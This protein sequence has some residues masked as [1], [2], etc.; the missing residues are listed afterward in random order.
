LA[1]NSPGGQLPLHSGR[2]W[3]HGVGTVELVVVVMLV[4]VVV[5]LVD[6]VAQATV[7]ASQQCG[8]E[9]G[10]PPRAAH[11]AALVSTRQCALPF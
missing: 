7:H 9:L 10:V 3:P 8:Q 1:Q 4:L 11:R 2:V 5:T 6:V